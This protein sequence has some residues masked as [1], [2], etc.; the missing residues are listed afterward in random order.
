MLVGS[1][2]LLKTIKDSLE[3]KFFLYLCTVNKKNSIWG[4]NL[5][6]MDLIM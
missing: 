4:K 1:F 3:Y 6:I 2:F 5:I